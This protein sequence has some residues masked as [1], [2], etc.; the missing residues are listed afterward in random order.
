MAYKFD[1]NDKTTNLSDNIF[2]I[3]VGTIRKNIG[4]LG[5]KTLQILSMIFCK[6]TALKTALC[7]TLPAAPAH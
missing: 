1:P 4:D 5:M 6:N 2:F 7:L 3:S